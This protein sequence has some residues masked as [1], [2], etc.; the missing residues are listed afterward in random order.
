[1]NNFSFLIE[2]RITV[3]RITSIIYSVNSSNIDILEV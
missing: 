3:V 1:M 2:F